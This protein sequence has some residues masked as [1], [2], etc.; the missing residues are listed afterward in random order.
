M[1]DKIKNMNGRGIVLRRS[2]GPHL[3]ILVAFRAGFGPPDF[4]LRLSKFGLCNGLIFPYI[5]PAL[6]YYRLFIYCFISHFS[7]VINEY[8]FPIE[9]ELNWPYFKLEIKLFLKVFY[10]N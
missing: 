10:Y 3:P 5:G 2:R 6:D 4:G 8:S 9:F 7:V 1:D